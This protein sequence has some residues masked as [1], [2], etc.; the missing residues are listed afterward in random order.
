MIEARELAN[1]GA[2]HGSVV[3]T[4]YQKSGRGRFPER[5]WLSKPGESVLATVL[6]RIDMLPLPAG[7]LPLVA[8]LAVVDFLRHRHGIR[9]QIKW[10]NDVLVGGQ[11]ISG[12]LCMAGHNHVLVGIGINCNQRQFSG[13]DNL[14]ATSIRLQ[15]G[16]KV[17]MN[18]ELQELLPFFK[19]RLE[20]QNWREDLFRNLAMKNRLVTANLGRGESIVTGRIVGLGENGELLLQVHDGENEFA[21]TSGELICYCP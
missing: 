13:M 10:P 19:T 1:S 11:K 8:G 5:R 2:P 12:I 17:R 14:S 20:K 21:I 4:S 16:V 18:A 9:A 6:L 7:T 15:L 3:Y